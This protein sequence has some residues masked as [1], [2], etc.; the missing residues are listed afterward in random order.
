MEAALAGW[1]APNRPSRWRGECLLPGVPRGARRQPHA[2]KLEGVAGM[3]SN[4]L[5]KA[6]C[7][8]S[9][10]C[11][12]LRHE[13]WQFEVDAGLTDLT[14]LDLGEDAEGDAH[15][16]ACWGHAGK[17]H[18]CLCPRIPPPR[19]PCP[20]RRS[21]YGAQ[22][23]PERQHG[24][25]RPSPALDHLRFGEGLSIQVMHIGPYT[26]GA[27]SLAKRMVFADEHGLA[28]RGK[29]HEIYIGDPRRA[30]PETL[31]TVLRQPVAR[32]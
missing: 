23:G 15:L 4:T 20:H 6:S 2:K 7:S 32:G 10:P 17:I 18:R 27:R 12:E 25:E 5:P 26:D 21:G 8:H 22:T 31:K 9:R 14:P 19:Q 30:K 13:G 11:A 29:H 3:I 16:F 28:C 1:T 24:K